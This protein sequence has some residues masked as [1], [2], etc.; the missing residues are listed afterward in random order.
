MFE[1]YLA[2]FPAAATME[3]CDTVATRLIPCPSEPRS[4]TYKKGARQLLLI[5]SI[6][7]KAPQIG[8][9]LS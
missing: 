7:H 8:I 2:I 9:F 6:Y 5:V 4:Y 3:L 1:A